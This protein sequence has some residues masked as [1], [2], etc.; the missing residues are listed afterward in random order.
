LPLRN[1]FFENISTAQPEAVIADNHLTGSYEEKTNYPNRR[2]RFRDPAVNG[3]AT[4]P[5]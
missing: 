1:K 4:R 2:H 5:P 3:A